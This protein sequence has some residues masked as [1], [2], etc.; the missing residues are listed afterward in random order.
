M[1][2]KYD[3]WIKKAKDLYGENSDN[4]EF[5]CPVCKIKTKAKEWREAK[6]E[7]ML[8]FSCIGRAVGAKINAFEEGK[9]PCNYAGGGLFALNPIKIVKDDGSSMNVFDFSIEQITS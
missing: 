8:A 9:G 3:D 5:V 2:I 7:G 6:Q 1:V 4:W